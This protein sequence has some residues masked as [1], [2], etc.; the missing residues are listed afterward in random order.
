MKGNLAFHLPRCHV[1][2][3]LDVAL[4]VANRTRDLDG[5][6]ISNLQSRMAGYLI[7]VVARCSCFMMQFF[8]FSRLGI[9]V[10][11]FAI[12]LATMSEHDVA[13][14]STS[15]RRPMILSCQR[16]VVLWT[17]TFTSNGISTGV[18][19]DA[20]DLS[21]TSNDDPSAPKTATRL[22]AASNV[23]AKRYFMLPLEM[24]LELSCKSKSELPT[25]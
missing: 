23:L 2:M 3:L 6:K 12:I 13:L 19:C 9:T 20:F 22:A 16:I 15:N 10:L 4:L 24:F 7:V 8:R 14:L 18:I 5:K 1:T 11:I 25:I 17:S 21:A